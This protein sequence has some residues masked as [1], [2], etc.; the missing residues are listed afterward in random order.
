MQ[1]IAAVTVAGVAGFAGLVGFAGV[2]QASPY[3]PQPV[4]VVTP[5]TVP[6]SGLATIKGSNVGCTVTW[7]GHSIGQIGSYEAFTFTSVP[8][9]VPASVGSPNAA[10]GVHPGGSAV[11]HEQLV[12]GTGSATVAFHVVNNYGQQQLTNLTISTPGC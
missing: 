1:R 10:N 9:S 7:T 3:H 12:P 4:H 5:P 8:A 11:S 6:S 2:A